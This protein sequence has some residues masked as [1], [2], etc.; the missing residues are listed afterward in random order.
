ML[1]SGA[2]AVIISGATAGVGRALGRLEQRALSVPNDVS[3]I[4]F[5]DSEL[6]AYKYPRLTVILRPLAEIGRLASRRV[7]A[8]LAAPEEAPR[9][10][11][12]KTRLLVRDST[13]APPI[14][15][16]SA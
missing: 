11:T 6:A 9:V 10:E 7:I 14:S 15:A 16:R 2:T 3:L 1:D 8:R 13:V 4:A 5:D 12:V